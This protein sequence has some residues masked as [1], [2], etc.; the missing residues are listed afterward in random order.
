MGHL[1]WRCLPPQALPPAVTEQ[2]FVVDA[3]NERE[4]SALF[5]TET[6]LEFARAILGWSCLRSLVL[7]ESRGKQVNSRL[8]LVLVL[9][10]PS[11]GRGVVILAEAQSRPLFMAATTA[12]AAGHFSDRTSTIKRIHRGHESLI[13]GSVVE[14]LGNF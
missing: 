10:V 5:G 9:L 4:I 8:T 1:A 3:L 6:A 2:G 11:P 14:V 13:T 7:V 12:S